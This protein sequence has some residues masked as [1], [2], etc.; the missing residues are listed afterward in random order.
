VALTPPESP[1]ETLARV[2]AGILAGL[3]GIAALVS[4][5]ALAADLPTATAVAEQGSLKIVSR[6]LLAPKSA[7]L[8]GVWLDA[9]RSCNEQRQLRVSILVD[10]V[11]G[12]TTTR[13]NRS[14]TGL[15]T[16]CA[17][18]GPNFG[19]TV[20]PSGL[21]MACP[22]GRWTP[23]RYVFVVRTFDPVSQLRAVATLSY[24]ETRHC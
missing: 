16:N 11:R 3:A 1:A 15:V 19:F 6:A 14:K 22:N 18:G 23:G 10:R 8:M 2:K 21:G 4:S 9:R 17:E 24:Q 12:A 13:R 5:V 20:T 7:E